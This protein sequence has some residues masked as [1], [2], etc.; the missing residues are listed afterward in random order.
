M[1]LGEKLEGTMVLDGLL[2]GRLPPMGDL[3][4][5]LREWVTFVGKIGPRFNLEIRGQQFSLLP[6]DRPFEAAGLGA[7]AEHGMSQALEQLIGLYGPGPER[8]QFYSTLRSSEFRKGLEVQTV[9]TIADGKVRLQ[10]RSMEAATTARPDPISIRQKLKMA[11]VGLGMAAL[12]VGVAMLFPGV[13]AMVWQVF[14]TARPFNATELT[15][16]AGPYAPWLTVAIDA[17]KSHRKGVV[18]VFTRTKDFPMTDAA[19]DA[20]APSVEKSVKGRMALENLARGKIRIEYFDKDGKLVGEREARIADL[21]KTETLP[22][23]FP[24][25]DQIIVTRMVLVP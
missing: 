1:E 15:V 13:R 19:L 21:S 3:A 17:E 22:G 20:A 8:S 7:G 16:D 2:Q 10:T 14:E 4:D 6:D 25:P 5:K 9:Y 12:L 11:L 18:L 23:F 24:L